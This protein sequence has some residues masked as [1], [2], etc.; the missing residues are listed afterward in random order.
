MATFA[1]T[2]VHDRGWDQA[3][4]IRAQDGWPAHAAFMDGLVDDGFLIL[5]GP[6]GGPAGGPDS[7]RTLHAV[8]ARDEAQVRTRLARDPWAQ[9][10]L[11]RIE[12]IEPWAW[13]LDSR[14]TT[15]GNPT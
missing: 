5:G 2:L 6:V 3:R 8:Q 9:S 15:R 7:D 1:V 10:G 14:E 13:W 12:H 11:L 4:P